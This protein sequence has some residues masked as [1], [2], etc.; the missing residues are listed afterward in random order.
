M[1][2]SDT[3]ALRPPVPRVVAHHKPHQAIDAWKRLGRN[4][5]LLHEVCQ[6]VKLETGNIAKDLMNNWCF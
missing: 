4:V 3:D 1:L 2:T 5:V 6:D